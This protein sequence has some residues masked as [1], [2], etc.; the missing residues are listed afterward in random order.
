MHDVPEVSS[1]CQLV[2]FTRPYESVVSLNLGGIHQERKVVVVDDD[3]DDDD[4]LL[5]E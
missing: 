1:S 4:V 3:D 5:P 2:Y